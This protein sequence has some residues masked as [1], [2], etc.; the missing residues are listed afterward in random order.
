MGFEKIFKSHRRE[1]QDL[2]FFFKWDDSLLAHVPVVI[3]KRDRRRKKKRI[4]GKNEK[5]TDAMRERCDLSSVTP[6]EPASDDEE[7]GMP[8]LRLHSQFAEKGIAHN[9][10]A[11][12]ADRS[13]DIAR[14][15][16]RLFLIADRRKNRRLIRCREWNLS[17]DPCI[18][19]FPCDLIGLFT[20]QYL[21]NLIWLIEK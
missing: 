18:W 15:G 12:Y 8:D 17:W 16:T 11:D 7:R 9:R 2:F 3:E 1:V 13:T 20:A 19:R 5:V 10:H 6:D 14:P 4:R 21:Y